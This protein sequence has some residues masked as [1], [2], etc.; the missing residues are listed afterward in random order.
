[1]DF[2]KLIG[3]SRAPAVDFPERFKQEVLPAEKSSKAIG[4]PKPSRGTQTQCHFQSHLSP[5]PGSADVNLHVLP[6]PW[7]QPKANGFCRLWTR[8]GDFHRGVDA[9]MEKRSCF[10]RDWVLPNLR[11]RAKLG[12]PVIYTWLHR[13]SIV[14]IPELVQ[15]E[16][17]RKSWYIYRDKTVINRW[18]PVDF[19]EFHQTPPKKIKRPAIRSTPGKF[20]QQGELQHHLG[21]L[22]IEALMIYV[23]GLKHSIKTIWILASNTRGMYQKV[24]KWWIWWL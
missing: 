23:L 9:A 18:L 14:G 21:R 16:I 20:F 3:S 11:F 6:H 8:L 17:W 22:G 13:S 10:W 12:E 19:P 2:R 1:M 24:D 4:F 15:R 7:Q 5:F